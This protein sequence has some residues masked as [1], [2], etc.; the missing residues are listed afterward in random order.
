MPPGRAHIQP[1]KITV[2]IGEP[3]FTTGLTLA[4][5]KDLREKVFA[6]MST[7]ISSNK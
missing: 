3:I 7:M 4:D 2:L 6:I 5:V 1:G